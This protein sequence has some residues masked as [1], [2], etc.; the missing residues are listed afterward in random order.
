MEKGSLAERVSSMEVEVPF[1]EALDSIPECE[2]FVLD[3]LDEI[4]T[5]E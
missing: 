3:L 5:E 1:A 4:D 2:E